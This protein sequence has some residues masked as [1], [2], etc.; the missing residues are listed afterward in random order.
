[1][2]VLSVAGQVLLLISLSHLLPHAQNVTLF[3]VNGDGGR[4]A[5][6]IVYVGSGDGGHGRAQ[7]IVFQFFC[8]M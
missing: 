8:L 5:Y 2:R 4:D 7:V 6:E 3:I 1:M